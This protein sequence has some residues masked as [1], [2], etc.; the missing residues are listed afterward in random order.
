MTAIRKANILT[1][2]TF[3]LAFIVLFLFKTDYDKKE[4]ALHGAIT[5]L[6]LDNQSLREIKSKDDKVILAQDAIITSSQDAIHS[7]TDTIF[8]LKSK[9]QKEIKSII[10][11]YKG[12][13]VTNIDS[14]EV[15][16]KDTIAM[17]QFEDSIVRQCIRVI[18]YM[19]DSMITVPRRVEE[20]TK[21]FR[22]AGTVKKDLFTIDSLSIPDTLQLRFVE[23]GGF[24]KKK[25][26]EVQFFHS[27]PLITTTQSNSVVYK[28]PKKPR[29]LEKA[30]IF[31]AG[32]F[33]GSKL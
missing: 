15:P 26:A 14:V 28:P 31:G 32:L 25:K 9:H 11:Y 1:I 10:S 33:L 16:Y 13:T 6:Q 30:L 8:N 18:Q 23:K 27:N 19:R 4:K 24:L 21:D 3:V 7:L 17:K 29:W 2:T 20:E 12:V 22:F 5:S